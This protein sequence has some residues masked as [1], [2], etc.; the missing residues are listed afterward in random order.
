LCLKK[1]NRSN[2]HSHSDWWTW[3][4]RAG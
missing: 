3:V 2:L 1:I 4:S